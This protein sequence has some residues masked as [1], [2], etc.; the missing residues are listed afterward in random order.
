M[1]RYRCLQ[2]AGF[3]IAM[4]NVAIETQLGKQNATLRCGLAL[5]P[6]NM[7]ALPIRLKDVD[8]DKPICRILIPKD[9]QDRSVPTWIHSPNDNLEFEVLQ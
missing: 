1:D 5:I 6:G 9:Y 2:G 7:N 8:S 3:Q 4:F